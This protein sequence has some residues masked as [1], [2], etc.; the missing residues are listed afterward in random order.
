MLD[1]VHVTI[2]TRGVPVSVALFPGFCWCSPLGCVFTRT[3]L[4]RHSSNCCESVVR[5]V[6]MRRARACAAVVSPVL[7]VI[8]ATVA[9]AHI[10]AAPAAA[11]APAPTTPS[12][13]AAESPFPC[14]QDLAG[15]V[16]FS[17]WWQRWQWQ[18]LLLPQHPVDVLNQRFEL[19]IRWALQCCW[20]G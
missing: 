4:L 10:P 16:F 3:S 14:A 6:P 2:A 11:A 18:W 8:V 1:P 20:S 7:H 15:T 13:E 19:L 5:G 17:S 9:P 12:P